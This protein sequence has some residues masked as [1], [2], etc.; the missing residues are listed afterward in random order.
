M[1]IRDTHITG[2]FVQDREPNTFIGIDLPFRK[3][4]GRDGWFAST[5][6]TIEAVK[7]NIRN[8]LQTQQGERYLQPILGINLRQYMFEQVSDDLVFKI[9]NSILD[10]FKLWLPFV[11]VNDIQIKTYDDDPLV[12]VNEIRVNILFNIKQDPNTVDSITIN[13]SSN[14]NENETSQAGGG[15]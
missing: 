12:G 15:Y 2:S 4:E 8:L 9:Q 10:T 5:E 6:T 13:F 11:E 3:S 7:N 14:V 1:A